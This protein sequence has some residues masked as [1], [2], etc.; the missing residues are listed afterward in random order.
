MRGARG[1][2]GWGIALALAPLLAVGLLFGII[3]L[4]DA[5]EPAP[6]KALGPQGQA[7]D[8]L[9]TPTSDPL[10]A[11]GQE[12]FLRSD[13]GGESWQR[14]SEQEA[15]WMA[16]GVSPADPDSRSVLVPINSSAEDDTNLWREPRGIHHGGSAWADP[17]API[18]PDV[19]DQAAGVDGRYLF[20]ATEK[21]VYRIALPQ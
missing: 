20:A 13:D 1:T 8:P 9:H 19:A 4:T 18:E 14:V 2:V 12:A 7:V 10:L 21:G 3:A 6:W 16:L 11:P 5:Q 17:G 15:R